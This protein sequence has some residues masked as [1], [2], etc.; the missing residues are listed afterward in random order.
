[1]GRC[2]LPSPTG[3][4]A[5]PSNRSTVRRQR[6]LP[7]TDSISAYERGRAS[8][9]I[10]AQHRADRCGDWCQLARD[11]GADHFGV[12]AAVTLQCSSTGGHGS[13]SS[14]S[15]ADGR[16][17][18]ARRSTA[19]AAGYP[20]GAASPRCRCTT[21]NRSTD[22]RSADTAAERRCREEP[23]PGRRVVSPGRRSGATTQ[24]RPRRYQRAAVKDTRPCG[25][26]GECG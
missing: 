14:P 2:G 1:M 20:S 4:S 22:G 10:A 7:I 13:Q 24:T 12:V 19:S 17:T 16:S 23:R 18:A 9:A 15:A 6:I 11:H 5:L 3:C 26:I 21:P 8:L 25:T